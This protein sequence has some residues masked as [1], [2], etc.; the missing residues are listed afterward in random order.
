VSARALRGAALV[1]GGASGLGAATVRRLH[2]EGMAVAAADIDEERG[3]AIAE[4]LGDRAAF[5]RVD[6]TDADELERAAR[7]AAELAPEGLRLSV[8]CAG[9]GP[10]ERLLGRKGPHAVER[11]RQVVEVNLFGTFNLMR[12]AAQSMAEN[13]PL[14]DERGVHLSTASAAAFEGQI[15]QLAYSASKA[16]VVGMT[17]PAARDLAERGIRVCTIAPGIFDTPLMDVL[18]PEAHESLAKATPFPQRLGRPDEYAELVVAVARNQMLNG[19]T[20]RLDG[21]IRLAPR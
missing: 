6:V 11:F 7:E 1:T 16:G 14:D 19:E 3:S 12:A 8:A 21:A 2:E 5:L 4:E 10:A 17:L 15:G 18:P 13:E 20:I 9:I